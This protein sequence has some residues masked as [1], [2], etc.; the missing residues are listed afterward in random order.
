MGKP[1]G[2]VLSLIGDTPIVR[3]DRIADGLPFD[4]LAKLEYINPSGSIKDRIA[5]RMIEEAERSGRIGPGSVIV[6]PTSGNTG[7]G[8]SMV[9]ALKGYRM[10]AVMP[11]A[12]SGERRMLMEYLGAEVDVVPSCC[13]DAS[14]G[15]TRDDIESTVARARELVETIPGA[16]MPNQFENPVNPDAHAETTAAEILEQTNGG[17]H[18][19]V[20]A[21]GTGG[22]FSG[23]AKVL[24]ARHPDIRRVVVEPAGSAVMSGCEA[25]YHKIQ[26]IGE[27][28][29]PHTMNT[30][31]ADRVIQV[32]DA[33]SIATARR[34]AR[35]EGMQ[36]KKSR[37]TWRRVLKCLTGIHR[38]VSL[39]PVHVEPR[40]EGG[41]CRW[42]LR[43]L[44]YRGT[45][46]RHRRRGENPVAG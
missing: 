45:S 24:K 43:E 6:E 21:C 33:A 35:E 19:F 41:L 39:R 12:M 8:L 17:F 15:F 34:L 13:H 10:I 37:C 31:L 22:T 25:G 26:G 18:A 32:D 16:F 1:I 46:G 28:F 44:E 4:I 7:I 11:E 42:L 5:L 2:S 3:L 23:V 20:A 27:G 40:P 36:E 9:C 29:I 14:R 38:A 30:E